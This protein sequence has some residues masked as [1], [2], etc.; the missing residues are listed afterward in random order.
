MN[1][2]ISY[3]QSQ[4]ILLEAF[5]ADVWGNEHIFKEQRTRQSESN[6]RT[7][8]CLNFGKHFAAVR[9]FCLAVEDTTIIVVQEYINAMNTFKS[10]GSAYRKGACIL[11]QPGIG[12]TFTYDLG[13]SKHELQGSPFS[14]RMKVICRH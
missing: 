8:E 5:R 2:P 6:I 3:L 11:G 9:S 13:I 10:G 7:I 14:S 12:M 1:F 4:L